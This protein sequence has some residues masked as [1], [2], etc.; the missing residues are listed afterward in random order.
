MQIPILYEDDDMVALDKPA[1]IAVHKDGHNKEGYTIADWLVEKYPAIV[2]V[3]EPLLLEDGSRVE[4]P[5]IVHRLDRDTTGVLLAAKNQPTYLYLKRQFQT[6]AIKKAYRLI[7]YG[8]FSKEKLEGTINVP[9]GRSRKDSRLRVASRKAVSVLREAIT[10]YRVLDQLPGYAYVE[11]H[12]KTGR[13]HQLRAHFKAAGHPII[14]D[15]LYASGQV[16]PPGLNRQALHAF[17]L[18]FRHPQKGQMKIES[19]LPADF[20]AALENLKSLC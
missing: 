5:G 15:S 1:G 9:I 13:T 7:V 18:E 14:C 4:K 8:N 19:E 11:A 17:S 16:C 2:G 6:H 3:G 10:Y 12:P 20:R